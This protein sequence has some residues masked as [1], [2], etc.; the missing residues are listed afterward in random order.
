LTARVKY[1]LRLAVFLVFRLTI[2]VAN[3]CPNSE[4]DVSK[5]D[6]KNLQLRNQQAAAAQRGAPRQGAAPVMIGVPSGDFVHADFTFALTMLFGRT[7]AAGV[8][9]GVT[10]I[11]GTLIDSARNMIVEQA[12]TH[13]CSHL[14][15]VDS[16]M[17]F[18]E[19][20]LLRLLA[21]DKD[22]VG[23]TYCTR[24]APFLM[25][26]HN[27]SELDPRSLLEP[28]GLYRV[29]ALPCGF[30]LVKMRVFTE[31][32]TLFPFVTDCREELGEDVYFCRLARAAGFDIWLDVDLSKDV[33]HC[34]QHYYSLTDAKPAD[35]QGN[36]LP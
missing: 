2:G 25:V 4:N 18:K 17:V 14:L 34:G 29:A 22:I 36:Y 32:G 10:N 8:P 23:A 20:A 26:H 12:L 33:R 21:R 27:L 9:L 5:I 13:G 3:S 35:L 19:D 16:D 31:L 1:I 6:L 11:K 7:M 28:I 15:F 24:R 30:L